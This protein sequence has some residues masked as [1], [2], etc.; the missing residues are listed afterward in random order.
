VLFLLEKEQHDLIL[1]D[2]MLPGDELLPHLAGIT[3][4]V[5]STRA[6]MEA[7]VNFLLG[8]AAN[9]IAKPFQFPE[10]LTQI[11]VQLRRGETPHELLVDAGSLRLD[12]DSH[13]LTLGGIPVRLTP[14]EYA[15]LKFL[16]QRPD[17]VFTHSPLLE[18]ISRNTPDCSDGSLKQ[19]IRNLDKTFT[20]SLPFSF[21]YRLYSGL[22]TTALS[23]SVSS[24]DYPFQGAGI[25]QT[26]SQ[27]IMH[28]KQHHHSFLQLLETFF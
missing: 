10:L 8:G 20:V 12:T 9:Y 11:T 26:H 3:I 25:Q 13:I 5:V 4:I 7:K 24:M 2:L 22:K 15:L 21:T 23:I 16:L 17:W 1:P 14:T 28:R 18:R 19:H 6:A 27:T